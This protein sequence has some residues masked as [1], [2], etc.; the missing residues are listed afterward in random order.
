MECRLYVLIRVLKGKKKD[1]RVLRS[2]RISRNAKLSPLRARGGPRRNPQPP[3]PPAVR[4]P[5]AP[6]ALVEPQWEPDGKMVF[7]AKGV[8]L[9]TTQLMYG[10]G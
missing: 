8:T 5:W 4:L 3:S 10:L 9:C 6:L 2:S 1:Q 7:L